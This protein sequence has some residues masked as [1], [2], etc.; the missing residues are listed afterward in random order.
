MASDPNIISLAHLALR[1]CPPWA[2]PH[3]VLGGIFNMD[4]ARLHPSAA[5]SFAD[6]L[7]RRL[8]S[9]LLMLRFKSCYRSVGVIPRMPPLDVA[10]F[11]QNFPLAR[12]DEPAGAFDWLDV[13]PRPGVDIDVK[14]LPIPAVVGGLIG[15]W[16]H[17]ELRFGVGNPT[18]QANHQQ[19]Q[20]GPTACEPAPAPGPRLYICPNVGW[21]EQ[22]RRNEAKDF[23]ERFGR[24]PEVPM[25]PD[26]EEGEASEPGPRAGLASFLH[27]EAEV[28]DKHRDSLSRTCP[29]TATRVPRHG[30]MMD[31]ETF[32]AAEALP[33]TAIG[34]WLFPADPS[35]WRLPA[36]PR[37]HPIDRSVPR[38][39]LWLFDV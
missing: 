15:A 35:I 4:P 31:A 34:M 14:Q 26:P 29:P 24:P 12:R 19:P 2:N 7:Q 39:G 20:Q 5:A 38:P 13:D 18:Q 1:T 30:I 17:L 16:K 9:V 8:R 25:L 28:W 10:H 37:V 11:P 27:A 36:G 32:E 6:I 22:E 23:N 3:V 33:C 21:S